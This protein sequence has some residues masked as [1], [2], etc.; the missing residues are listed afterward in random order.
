MT[1]WQ[2][3]EQQKTGLKNLEPDFGVGVER[4]AR[5][6]ETSEN[7]INFSKCSSSFEMTIVEIMFSS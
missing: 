7:R 5:E 4:K 2:Q 6:V 3:R 1:I